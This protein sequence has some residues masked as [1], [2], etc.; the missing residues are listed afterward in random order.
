M[1]DKRSVHGPVNTE[2]WPSGQI[3][4]QFGSLSNQCQPEALFYEMLHFSG[5]GGATEFSDANPGSL[6]PLHHLRMRFWMPF[7]MIQ[8]TNIPT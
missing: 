6:E 4:V 7:R 3:S 5:M 1:V 8:D 2:D